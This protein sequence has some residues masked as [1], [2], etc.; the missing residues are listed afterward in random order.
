[1][2]I[3][4]EEDRDTVKENSSGKD[5]S[6]E[7]EN[8]TN[9]TTSYNPASNTAASGVPNM[10]TQKD[11]RSSDKD[12]DKDAT[13]AIVTTASGKDSKVGV[14]GQ[15]KIIIKAN[16]VSYVSDKVV[17]NG[18]FGVVFQ[19]S[20]MG[21]GEVVAIKKVLQDK[22]FKNR[23]LQIMRLLNHPN[24]VQLKNS[25][26]TNGD[27]PDEV[28]LNLVLEYVP[29]TVYRVLRHYAKLKQQVPLIYTK[30]YMYQLLRSLAYIHSL[31]IC[32]RDIKPQNL[33]LDQQTGVLKLCDFGS[34]KILVK[35]E[36]NVSYICSRYYRAP[37]LLFGST[38]YSTSIDIWSMG[39]VLAEMLMGT[40]LFPGDSGVDQLVEIIKVLGT[41]TRE[42]IHA[43]N[44]NYTAFK[45]PQIKPHTLAK[46]FRSRTPPEAVDLV[47]KLLQYTP[48]GRLKPL[49]ACAHPFFDELRDPNS[50][51]P[52]SRNLPLLFNF[53][54]TEIADA[55]HLLPKLIPPHAAH[56]LQN[57]NLPLSSPP[58]S[59]SST[60]SNSSPPSTTATT[61][62]PTTSNNT[63][64]LTQV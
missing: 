24:V 42:Q 41:P 53:T 62:A 49:E 1:M 19:A 63:K 12:K 56:E 54:P 5:T 3:G 4:K 7:R 39:C 43:M 40:P 17:G 44:Q 25:F 32:H 58:L 45:F 28:F 11:L 21:T 51:L 13:V 37:E 6:K 27:K 61:T 18:S 59:A 22:R 26:F 38:S 64:P 14:L 34:A 55:K 23:E 52:N 50:R 60:A 10:S 16:G 33:L 2:K 46:V 15:D 48:A 8:T 35:N 57:L 36:P 31:G 30:V 47:S 29:D 9:N 20:V